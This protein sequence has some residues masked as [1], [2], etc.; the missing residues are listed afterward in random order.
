MDMWQ[1]LIVVLICN[2]PRSSY[3]EYLLRRFTGLLYSFFGEVPVKIFCLFFDW[4]VCLLTIDLQG[5]FI[6]PGYTSFTTYKPGTL[7]KANNGT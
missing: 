5:L 6:Y 7:L 1:D 4:V 2:S 3:I